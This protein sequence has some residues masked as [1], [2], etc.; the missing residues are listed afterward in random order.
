MKE[1]SLDVFALDPQHIWQPFFILSCFFAPLTPTVTLIFSYLFSAFFLVPLFL[2]IALPT[3]CL[4][5]YFSAAGNRT[6][7]LR[8]DGDDSQA[9]PAQAHHCWH[10]RLC[11]PHWLRPHQ[12]G[13]FNLSHSNSTHTH[14]L[15]DTLKWSWVVSAISSLVPIWRQRLSEHSLWNC[16]IQTQARFRGFF[17]RFT[18]TDTDAFFLSRLLIQT[19]YRYAHWLTLTKQRLLTTS[20]LS[21]MVHKRPLYLFCY[22][23]AHSHHSLCDSFHL[24]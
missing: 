24:L 22:P 17:T 7:R 18:L 4:P 21:V 13:A 11:P 3:I 19:G 6:Y 8:P 10:Q 16:T 15:T 2:V 23:P 1:K 20:L 12:E 9:V 5:L 14:F